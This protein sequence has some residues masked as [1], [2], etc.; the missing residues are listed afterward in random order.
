MEHRIR[1]ATAADQQGI[2]RLVREAR[3]NPRSLHWGRFVVA[4]VDGDL[5]GVAQV[6]RHRD[7]SHELASLVVRPEARGRGVAANM[8]EMVLDGEPGPVFML[9]DRRFARHYQRWAFRPV[10]PS[11]LPTSMR[12]QLRIGRA[13]TALGSLLIRRRIALVALRRGP[14]R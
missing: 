3:L 1:R 4:E 14:R 7:G 6:R 5:L 13:V 10:E 11:D 9:V 12:R 2:T 8:I